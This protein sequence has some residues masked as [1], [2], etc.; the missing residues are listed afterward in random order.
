LSTFYGQVEL[1]V[2][3]VIG[4]INVGQVQPR[5]LVVT[6]DGEVY[7]GTLAASAITLDL[8]TGQQIQ[9]PLNQVSRVGYRK[10]ADEPEEWTFDRPLVLMRQGDR[11]GIEPPTEPIEVVTRYGTLQLD[12][13]AIAAVVFQS[14]DH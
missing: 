6:R 7:G 1:P 3:K 12:P 14:D 9:V 4:L 10:R 13:Q 8:S 11:V 2:E 5:Q